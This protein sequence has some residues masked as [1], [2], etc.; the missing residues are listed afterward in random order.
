ML[1]SKRNAKWTFAKFALYHS[2]F[3]PF[4]D[5]PYL[6]RLSLTLLY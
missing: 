6:A 5:D 2:L 3:I 1:H 4:V